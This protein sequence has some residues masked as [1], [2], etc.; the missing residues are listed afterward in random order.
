MCVCGWVAGECVMI[1][2][3]PGLLHCR[4][5]IRLGFVFLFCIFRAADRL[6]RVKAKTVR[7]LN[8]KSTC[9]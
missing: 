4:F 7:R 1:G 8:G 5:I 6:E 3:R 9:R 2:F